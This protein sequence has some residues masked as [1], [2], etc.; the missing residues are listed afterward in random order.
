MSKLQLLIP[1]KHQNVLSPSFLFKLLIEIRE[2]ILSI[3]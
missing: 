2:Q 1:V 3:R